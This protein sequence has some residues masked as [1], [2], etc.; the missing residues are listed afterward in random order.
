[1][2]LIEVNRYDTDLNQEFLLTA[3][4]TALHVP[5]F[6]FPTIHNE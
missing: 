3:I 1:M 6:S 4:Y 2:T 5:T